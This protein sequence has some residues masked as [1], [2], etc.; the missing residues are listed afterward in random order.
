MNTK[1]FIGWIIFNILMIPILYIRPEKIKYAVLGMNLVTAVTLISMVIWV[2]TQADGG[3]PLLRGP[4]QVASSWDL[5]WSIVHGVT[6]VIGGI[7]VGLV[8]IKP[9]PG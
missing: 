4:A 1:Q 3:G 2:M 6:T 8:R 5:G 7:A 9:R